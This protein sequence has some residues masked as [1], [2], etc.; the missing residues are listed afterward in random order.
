MTALIV[1]WIILL[2]I[3]VL[4]SIGLKGNKMYTPTWKHVS[5]GIGIILFVILL[6][7]AF[8]VILHRHKV[9]NEIRKFKVSA[10]VIKVAKIASTKMG[11][12]ESFISDII[13]DKNAWLSG[14]QSDN[15]G[16]FDIWI[17]DE[18]DNL[19]PLR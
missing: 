3:V 11:A 4:I 13:I 6:S 9:N 5:I 1:M 19:K 8:S 15:N 14:R 18:I 10:Q 7:A 2:T 12:G 16:F 17:P